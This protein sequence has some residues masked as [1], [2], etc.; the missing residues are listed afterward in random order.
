M[1]SF[2]LYALPS[3]SLYEQ[4]EYLSTDNDNEGSLTLTS[5][6]FLQ[7][8]GFPVEGQIAWPFA[9]SE[10][11]LVYTKLSVLANK[12]KASIIGR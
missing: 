10:A 9:F 4:G 3:I 5:V 6:S 7:E 12:R 1:S 8:H 2:S 11:E